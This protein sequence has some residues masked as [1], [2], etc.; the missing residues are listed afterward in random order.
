LEEANVKHSKTLISIQTSNSRQHQVLE[1][2]NDSIRELE[3]L[4]KDKDQIIKNTVEEL[5]NMSTNFNK[6]SQLNFENLS[7]I[8]NSQGKEKH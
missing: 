2:K 8:I 4:I 5:A 6:Q 1:A 7:M 3:S